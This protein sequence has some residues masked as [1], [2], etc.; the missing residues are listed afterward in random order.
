MQIWS[1]RNRFVFVDK[2]STSWV[3]E[4]PHLLPAKTNHLVRKGAGVDPLVHNKGRL[5]RVGPQARC[6][7][8]GY[9]MV[10]MSS[11]PLP[12]AGTAVGFAS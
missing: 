7:A 5:V 3:L 10:T 6:P 1:G 12:G 9:S 2:P 8:H 4:F 11:F